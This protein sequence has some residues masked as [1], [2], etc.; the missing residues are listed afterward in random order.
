MKG[1]NPRPGVLDISP[2]VPGPDGVDG[3]RAAYKLSANESALGCSPR[4]IEAF[5]AAGSELH[6]YPDGS[7]AA[8][9]DAIARV[10]GL[11]PRRIVCGAGSDEILQLIARAYLGPGDAMVQTAHGF[12]VYELAATACGARTIKAPERR[13]TADVDAILECID[14]ST[15]IVFLANPNNPTG[16]FLPDSEIRRLRESLADDV[17][18]VVDC[19]YAEYM[20]APEYGDPSRLVDDFGAIAGNVVVTRTFSKIYGLGGLRLG[21]GYCPTN[22]A[23]VLNRIRGPFNI[24]APAI[25]AGVAA[26]E[27]QEFVERN[28]AHNS[29]ERARLQQRIGGLGLDFVPSV[30]NFILVRFA[31]EGERTAAAADAFLASRGIMVR[32]VGA[33]GLPDFLRVSIGSTDANDAFLGALDEFVAT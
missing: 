6:V 4:A 17:L 21:W 1:P 20:D 26:M 29:V 14:E 25:A 12:L 32:R 31:D 3:E 19:A 24:S 27:D 13:F 10:H 5:R 23:D 8:L 15:R 9:R 11:D 18:L 7:A 28:R 33:Y 16:T 2:Y 22:V 30:A